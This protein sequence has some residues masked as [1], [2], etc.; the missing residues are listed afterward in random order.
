MIQRLSRKKYIIKAMDV[1]SHND[2]ESIAKNET[3]VWLGCYIDE[4]S[5]PEDETSYFYNIDEFL[6]RIR[7]ESNPKRKNHDESRKIKNICIYIYNLSFEWSFILPALLERGF[8]YKESI[9]KE[10]KYVYNSISTRSVSSVWQVQIKFDEKAGIIVFRD[11]AKIFGGGLGAVAKAFNLPTQKGEIDYRL[12]RLHNHIVTKEEK[13]Y[14]FRD[15]RIL[16][17]ILLR[18]SEENDRDFWNSISMA[19]YSMRRLIKRGWPSA[20]R[21]FKEYR[22][23][24]PELDKEE[25]EFLRRSVS[26]GITYACDKWQF[27]EI[28]KKIGHIDLHQAHPSSAY[29]NLFPHGVGTYFEGRPPLGKR[30]CC[31][32][33]ISY[34]AVRIHSVIQLIG[35]SWI[36]DK[37]IVIW[38]FEIPTMKKCYINL[39]IEYL[40]GYA[41][42]M[43]PLPWRK[44]YEDNYNKRKEAKKRHDDFF[45][46]LYKLW[47][48]SSY[49]KHLEKPHNE[50]FENIIDE[51][52]IITSKIKEKE[53]VVINAK[54]TYIPVGACIPAFTRITLV[55]SAL[56]LGWENVIYFDT[57]SIFF[58]MNEESMKAWSTFNQKDFLGGWGW[59]ETIDRGQFSAPKR[60][61]IEVDGITQIKAGG[62]NFDE[63]KKRVHHDEFEQYMESS[64]TEKEALSK[65][66][67]PFDEINIIS[68]EWKVQRAYRCK[69]GT[70]IHFQDKKMDIQKKYIDIY[71]KNKIE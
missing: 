42:D 55:E 4:N 40:D 39:E 51:D 45:T 18:M 3:S 14:C 25:S 57:D 9:E 64:N 54:Y 33:K 31:R 24:Y 46:L 21:P 11:L 41:Y 56:Q 29:Y 61:K 35:L 8:I 48:N 47:N 19:S 13:D 59:E 68:S 52:G 27:K 62:I 58:I 53:N 12:N 23:S 37:E 17:D 28:N 32:V 65:I 36:D 49:G 34:S 10:D 1:E 5:S 63:Y 50:V 2:N 44:Y 26:G 22:K 66:N 38:D 7:D 20:F 70:L 30:C 69:G 16:I 15:T 43:K 71:N 6:D 67:L 60:Y